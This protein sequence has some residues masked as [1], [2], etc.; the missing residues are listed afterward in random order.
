MT[1]VPGLVANFDTRAVHQNPQDSTRRL[2]LVSNFLDK[3]PTYPTLAP[4]VQAAVNKAVDERV[5]TLMADYSPK[6]SYKP[7]DIWEMAKAGISHGIAAAGASAFAI[8]DIAQPIMQDVLQ[9]HF[10]MAAGRVIVTG[11]I[12]TSSVYVVVD[13]IRSGVK[14]APLAGAVRRETSRVVDEHSSRAA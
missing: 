10:A 9:G 8:L 14:Y 3:N 11:L 4:D 13:V 1:K 7:R 12:L 5:K 6:W 2:A